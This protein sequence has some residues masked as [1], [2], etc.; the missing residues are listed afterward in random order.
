M[1]PDSV[2]HLPDELRHQWSLLHRCAAGQQ[3]KHGAAQQLSLHRGAQISRGGSCCCHPRGAGRRRR[4]WWF[5]GISRGN[6]RGRFLSQGPLHGLLGS[7]AILYQR[8][9]SEATCASIA[10]IRTTGQEVHNVRGN[11]RGQLQGLTEGV[12][13][14]VGVKLGLARSLPK[15]GTLNKRHSPCPPSPSFIPA[16]VPRMSC[17]RA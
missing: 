15:R 14:R 17:C 7:P 10:G 16:I 9:G 3:R 5:P 13:F 12:D 8:K 1:G 11:V 2:P 6:S 4:Q